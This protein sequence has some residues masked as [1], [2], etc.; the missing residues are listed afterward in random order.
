[1]SESA[2]RLGALG[3]GSVFYGAEGSGGRRRRR[4]ITSGFPRPE[5]STVQPLVDGHGV[6][7]PR[8]TLIQGG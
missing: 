8:S 2:I 3:L 1:V 4:E 7:D 5:Y 6:H